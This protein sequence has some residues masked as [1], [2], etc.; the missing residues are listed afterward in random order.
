M[1]ISLK[2]E[3]QWIKRA[4]EPPFIGGW[5]IFLIAAAPI[6]LILL[7]NG[8]FEIIDNES[9][10]RTNALVTAAWN[11]VLTF[12]YKTKISILFIPCWLLFS[13]IGILRLL[14]IIQ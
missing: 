12:V 2:T 8:L 11:A 6:P 14:A 1:L 4:F 3:I 9:I 7:I 13:V 10:E 5:L